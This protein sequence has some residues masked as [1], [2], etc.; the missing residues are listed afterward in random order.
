MI[1][2]TALR[3]SR[4]SFGTGSLHHLATR[5]A[6]Q[7]LLGHASELGFSHFD[8][9]PLYGFGLAEEELGIFLTSQSAAL[10]VATKIGLYPPRASHPST[11]SVWAQKALSRALP[12][13]SRPIVDWSLEAAQASL[14]RSLR[15][16]QRDHI[17]V[18]FLHEPDPRLIDADEVTRWLEAQ[19]A[20]GKVRYY[21][22]AGDS[23]RFLPWL[24]SDHAVGEVLQMRD[25]LN[26][27][28]ADAVRRAGRELQFTFGYVSSRA[29]GD[30]RSVPS[31]IH[32][33]LAR[34][35]SGSV[36]VSTRRIEHV[37]QLS[38]AASEAS[39]CA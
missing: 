12:S 5:R 14:D 15:R 23:A 33:A 30:A 35:Q 10:T 39:A 31:L 2:R 18:L 3:V 8:T 17:D 34:S 26:D 11:A 6:R 13:L 32:A 36:L 21:G 27:Q 1:S 37:G 25:S 4:L 16:L 7:R 19:R 22:L 38:A 20:L 29:E 28:P 9:A 24:A